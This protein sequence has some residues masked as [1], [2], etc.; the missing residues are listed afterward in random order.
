MATILDKDLLRES[1]Q[2]FEDREI[3]VT[4][5]EKQT[6]SF[7]LK[8]L[9]SGEVSIGIL[10][11]YKQLRGVEEPDVKLP[12]GKT[13]PLKEPKKIKGLDGD[14]MINLY[15]LRSLNL[16]TKMDFKVKMELEKL[17]CE[18]IKQE[19]TIFDENE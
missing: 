3:M 4:L 18:I 15:R 7:K 6:I 2:K 5:T 19:V 16:V 17:L 14:P 13:E 8:G 1:T 11:L 12:K 9:K 10:P